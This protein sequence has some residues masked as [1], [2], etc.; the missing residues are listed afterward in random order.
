MQASIVGPRRP[1]TWVRLP[2]YMW[3]PEL[4]NKMARPSTRTPSS[5][6]SRPSMATRSP[7]PCGRS[8]RLPSPSRADGRNVTR[9]RAA[10][11]THQVR[12]WPST[13]ATLV[14]APRDK[15]D[16]LWADIAAQVSFDEKQAPI[17][18]FLGAHH[19]FKKDGNVTT[20]T[21]PHRR[22]GGF[23]EGRSGDLRRRDWSH[24]ACRGPHALRTCPR[25]SGISHR[26]GANK[27]ASSQLRALRT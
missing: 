16:K 6:S 27:R 2:P 12:C 10:G 18:K 19:V 17:G 25:T 13:S 1:A 22:D 5:R 26:R 14:V 24:E 11:F 21:D 3:L 15:E 20:L 7:A 8:T 23:H 4:F 9:T